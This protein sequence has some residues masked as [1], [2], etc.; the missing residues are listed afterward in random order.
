MEFP[1]EE[2]RRGPPGTAVLAV[3]RG[4][5]AADEVRGD[6]GESGSQKLRDSV[7]G[8]GVIISTHSDGSKRE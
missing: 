3:V 2:A 7:W 1:P 4:L 5:R 8:Q 6:K